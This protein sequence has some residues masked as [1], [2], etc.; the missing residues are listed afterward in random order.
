MTGDGV[1]VITVTTP[2]RVTDLDFQRHMGNTAFTDL[3]ADAR[4][5][6]LTDQ[7]WPELDE[8]AHVIALVHLE[9][10][11]L[12]QVHHP[13]TVQT[14]TRI[15]KVGRT[16]LALAQEMSSGERIVARASSVLVLTERSTGSAIRWPAQVTGADRLDRTTDR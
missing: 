14:T 9:V 4:F 3:F 12:D 7:I 10:D 5:A 15:S 11:F 13:A 2:I 8:Q 6:F 1:P 16:S